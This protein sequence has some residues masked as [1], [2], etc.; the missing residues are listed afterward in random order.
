MRAQSYV[1]DLIV[2]SRATRARQTLDLA[3]APLTEGLNEKPRIEFENAIYEVSPEKLLAIVVTVGCDV[4]HLM[5]V[6]H[7]PALEALAQLLVVSGGEQLR[8]NMCEKFPTAAL[9]VID[10]KCE[11][12]TEI[13]QYGGLLSEFMVPRRLD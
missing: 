7:N 2:C 13:K 1:P 10:F 4:R 5:V 11:R 6:G 12:W 3:F 8:A 9:A